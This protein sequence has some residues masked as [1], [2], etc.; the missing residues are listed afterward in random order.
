MKFP[1]FLLIGFLCFTLTSTAQTTFRHVT[2]ATNTNAHITTLDHPQLN[3]NANAMVFVAPS[4]EEQGDQNP[5]HTFGVW[6]NGSRWTIFNQNLAAMSATPTEH[7]RFKVLVFPTATANTFVHTVTAANKAGHIT[8]LDHPWLNNNPNAV[9]LVTQLYGVYNPREIGV[10]YDGGRWKI[11]NQDLVELPSNAKFNVLIATGGA[12]ISG[13][14][15]IQHTHT[16]ASKLGAPHVGYTILDNPAINNTGQLHLFATQRWIGTY[17]TRNYNIWYDDP[18]PSDPYHYRDGKWFI[19]DSQNLA[20]PDNAAFN[21][22]AVSAGMIQNTTP[23]LIAQFNTGGDDLR[24]GNDNVHLVVL[25]K[26]GTQLRFENVNEKKSW[27][28]NSSNKVMRALPAGTKLEDIVG[29]R[30]ET[31]FS[32]GIGGDNWNL[33]RLQVSVQTGSETRQLYDKQGTPLFRFTGDQRVREFLFS[34][35]PPVPGR[36][37]MTRF[38]PTVH[39]FKFVNRFTVPVEMLGFNFGSFSGLCGGMAYA[40][41]DYYNAGITIPQ[42]NYMPARGMPL[43]DYLLNRQLNSVRSNVDKWG[44]YGFNPGGARNRE[45]FNWGVQ[46]GSGR[47]GELQSRIDRGEPVPLGLWECGNDCGCPE[48]KCPGSH[49]ILAI[50]YDMGRYRGDVG[51]NIEDVSIFVYDPNYPNRTLT[52]RPHVDGAMYLYREEGQDDEMRA[53]RWRAYFTDMK[54]TRTTPPVIPN[55]PNELIATFRTGGDDLRGGNDNVH[56]VLL[57]RSG[58]T[59]RFENVN[60]KQRWADG[61]IQPVSR[62]LSPTFKAED[63]VGVR[64]ETTS[65]GG[66][67]G[68]NWN[69]E[70]LTIQLKLNG[71]DRELF[72]Q[73]GTPL[74]RFT[75][76]QKVREFRF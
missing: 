48:G 64:I 44:E 24:G 5:V 33:D 27:G 26:S 11:F 71:V 12:G 38:D 28:N 69:M 68:D 9:V 25:L 31:T 63:L 14:T 34:S 74:F 58:A 36:R 46:L 45:F 43:Y 76:D 39:G 16:N 3:G 73:G 2:N 19:Y 59:I 52:L 41:L 42:Q 17:N 1:I 53:C 32:G 10:W 50:G 23:N 15:A 75:G 65:G 30:I 40:A 56:L 7:F 67:G 21:I 13:A 60:D 72:R 47:L 62:P 20:M 22:L 4:W 49:Q 6:Y 35:T 57:M 55:N 51:A 61:S 8:T 18:S 29:V 37:V 66:I 54:Y 70:E